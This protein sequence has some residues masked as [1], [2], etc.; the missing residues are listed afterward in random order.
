MIDM[1]DIN[2]SL[3]H[4]PMSF[5]AAHLDRSGVGRVVVSSGIALRCYISHALSLHI[6]GI[7]IFGLCVLRLL[8]EGVLTV[9]MYKAGL[10]LLKDV[11]E[12]TWR[13]EQMETDIGR[14]IQL[15]GY[16]SEYHELGNPLGPIS[17]AL[18]L[19][20]GGIQIFGLCVLR[21][22]SEG[23]GTDMAR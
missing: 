15:A 7:Q 20:I 9:H 11:K 2:S 14:K 6:G 3:P 12:L 5:E 8:S 21:L 18:S 13:V 10:Y 16:L 22:L 17:H 19:H 23:Q 1:V 4:T